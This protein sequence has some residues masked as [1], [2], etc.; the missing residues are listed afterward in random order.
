MVRCRAVAIPGDVT[1]T[2]DGADVEHFE[3][4][5]T[6]A[7][8]FQ[9]PEGEKVVLV[10]LVPDSL[11]VMWTPRNLK[12]S[13]QLFSC[14]IHNTLWTCLYK[15]CRQYCIHKHNTDRQSSNFMFFLGTELHASIYS[16]HDINYGTGW[17]KMCP[18]CRDWVLLVQ[19]QYP[20][21]QTDRE[22]CSLYNICSG[23]YVQIAAGFLFKLLRKETWAISS[24]FR[25][26][27]NVQNVIRILSS[28]KEVSRR[29]RQGE[30]SL[31]TANIISVWASCN[32][33]AVY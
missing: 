22:G 4:L 14:F 31:S 19:L 27:K 33:F 9:S 13:T 25:R 24:W 30:S 11:L 15:L 28:K 26:V 20:L 32:Q 2:L 8:S 23:I 3:D 29:G 6:H 7:K 17:H 5:V 12:L 10:C 16:R 18:K 1:S 21:Q